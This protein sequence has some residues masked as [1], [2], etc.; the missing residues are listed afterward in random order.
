M[1][2]DFG[3]RMKEFEQMEAGRKALPLLPIIIRLDGK[4]FSRWTKG[5]ERPFDEK[6]SRLM[7][8][9]T[10]QLVDHFNACV[11]YTQ[12]D[13]ISLVLYSDD[14]K[15][16]N[17]FNGKI[18][19]LVSVSASVATAYFNTYASRIFAGKPLAFFDSRVWTVP[20]KMEA[21][22]AILWREQDA[23]KNSVSM[24]AREYYSHKELHK[25][26][27][28]DMMDMLM[29]KGVNWNNYPAFFK[30]GTFVQRVKKFSKFTPDE[31][32]R[33]P[34]QHAARNNPDLQIERQVIEP[35]SMPPFGKVTNRVEVIFDGALPIVGEENGH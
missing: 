29:E 30:R 8:E 1:V 19:K 24:A 2:D 32:E 16:E 7:I 5:L 31:I 28:A 11:G 23:T 10:E 33:L 14:Y 9:V 15:K 27:R 3:D 17:Y 18:Q 21:A 6:L 35:V 25:Q 4:G 20:N 26:G 34:A 22:N 13:E 12:S